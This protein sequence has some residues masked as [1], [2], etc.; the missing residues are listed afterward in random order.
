MESIIGIRIPIIQSSMKLVPLLDGASTELKVLMVIR[1]SVIK[2][3]IRPGTCSSFIQN[4]AKDK[5]E[6]IK[7]GAK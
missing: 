4:E 2:S 1:Q 6:N 3:P 7:V 5:S